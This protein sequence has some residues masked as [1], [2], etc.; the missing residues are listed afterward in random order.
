VDSNLVHS[1][2]RPPVGLLCQPQ[3]SMMMEKLAEWWLAGET[4]VL[5]VNLPQ[6]R[7]V[8]H[9]PHT[10]C[11]DANPGRRGGKPAINH[12]SCG[13]AFIHVLHFIR[14]PNMATIFFYWWGGTF[15]AAATAGILYEPQMIGHG[16]CGE[17]GGMKIGR[18]NRST[19][20]KLAPAP[21]CL[22]HIPHD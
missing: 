20:R 17:I 11:P 18:G 22:S 13:T 15:G 7:V 4:E 12:L 16:D 1:A 2:L 21:L 6:F 9:K 14:R 10:L 3:V 8:H 19:R 5:G